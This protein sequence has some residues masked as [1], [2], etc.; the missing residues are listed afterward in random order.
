MD[1]MLKLIERNARLTNAEIA[2]MLNEDVAEI[3]K[4][5]D[6]Y[7]AAGVIRGTRALIDWQKVGDSA[8]RAII[9]VRV[10]PTKGY[11]YDEVAR[12]IAG[13]DEVEGVQLMSGGYDL[14]VYIQGSSFQEIAL[15]VQQ[16][17]SPMDGVLSCS[18]HFVLTT[19][20]KDGALYSAQTKD[21]RQVQV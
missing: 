12:A 16:R 6:A 15:F 11:G 8:V 14:T 4:R 17:L 9:E 19:Y 21:E 3:T 2:G 10:T 7:K 5:M 13:F 20:K 18:T 1:K